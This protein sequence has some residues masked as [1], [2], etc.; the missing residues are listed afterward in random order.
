MQNDINRFFS[1]ISY[2]FDLPSSK[3]SGVQESCTPQN[4]EQNPQESMMPVTTEI[5][6][7]QKVGQRTNVIYLNTDCNLRCEYC[8]EGD[9]REGM[10]DKA[11]LTTDKIDAFLEEIIDREA[12][13]HNSTVV[14]MG[15]EPFLRFDLIKYTLLKAM[16][17]PHSFGI[18][19]ITNGTLLTDKRISELKYLLD[20]AKQSD[21]SLS[22]EVSYD[23][24]GQNRRYFPGKVDSKELVENNIKK[25][26]DVGIRIKISYTVHMG[27]YKNIVE[28][29]IYIL[30]K[31]NYD[32]LERIT[33]GFRFKDGSPPQKLICNTPKF[34]LKKLEFNNSFILL[35][36]SSVFVKFL[37]WKKVCS[38][39]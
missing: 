28:D 31:F 12:Q 13:F 20:L 17:L 29:T 39:Q 5:P 14:V 21:V 24:S 1:D 36:K 37:L 23:G 6:Q 10:P 26:L 16:S 3:N 33:I 38:K 30:E 25:L 27:N 11:H 18:S 19:L 4:N 15:G 7:E 2:I 22:L 32:D 35:I 8:Y 34:S 9:S